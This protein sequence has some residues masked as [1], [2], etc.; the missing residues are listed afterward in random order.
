M[1]NPQ[2]SEPWPVSSPRIALERP[3]E[4]RMSDAGAGS[5]EW[6]WRVL[7]LVASL[8]V[9]ATGWAALI[10]AAHLFAR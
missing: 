4:R 2:L 3:L 5:R 10:L 9:S 8:V 1:S 7:G 6:Y